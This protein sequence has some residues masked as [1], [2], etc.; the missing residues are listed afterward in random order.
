MRRIRVPDVF[1]L[2]S[3]T[4]DDFTKDGNSKLKK[5]KLASPI[6]LR[7]MFSSVLV[8]D[9]QYFQQGLMEVI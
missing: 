8:S 7:F 4:L 2:I 3:V 9:L 6:D 5:K 1:R